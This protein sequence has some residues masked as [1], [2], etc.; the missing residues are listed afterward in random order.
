MNFLSK[1]IL[2]HVVT[3]ILG[4]LVAT[5]LMM[6][7]SQYMGDYVTVG[8][9]VSTVSAEGQ[10]VSLLSSIVQVDLLQSGREP[11]A[12][13]HAAGLLAS[14]LEILAGMMEAG[15]INQDVA[16]RLCN[17]DL[18]PSRKPRAYLEI[19]RQ[20]EQ[21]SVLAAY[22]QLSAACGKRFNQARAAKGS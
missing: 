4:A 11:Q 14:N 22:D 6:Q 20:Q 15:Q 21:K 12:R 2:V 5:A 8:E 7:R 16:N 1:S 3:F 19:I 10:R 18:S 13:A 17:E 9:F